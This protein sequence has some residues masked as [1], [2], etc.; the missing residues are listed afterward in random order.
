MRRRS[1]ASSPASTA[2]RATTPSPGH[3]WKYIL[4]RQTNIDK[5]WEH[6]F[7]LETDPLEKTN[8][9]EST[10]PDA[11]QAAGRAARAAAG[12]DERNAA[13]RGRLGES[14]PVN[15]SPEDQQAL[16]SLGYVGG[17]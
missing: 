14:A 16:K 8:L 13:V 10:T 11:T 7:H 15:M 9:I 6:L 17:H 4:H 5:T 2:R 12:F 3:G 1:S